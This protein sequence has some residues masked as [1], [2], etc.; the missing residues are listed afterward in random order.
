MP[1]RLLVVEDDQDLRG[2][3]EHAFESRG[4]S[5]VATDSVAQ[6]KRLLDSSSFDLVL[7]DVML[8][9]GTGYEVCR[10]LRE[11]PSGATVPVIMLTA[12]DALS[13]KEEGFAAGADNYLTKP[14]RIEELLLWVQALLRR[15][16]KDWPQGQWTGV[17][18]LQV[19]PETR[20]VRCAGNVVRGLTGKEFSLLLELARAAG[21]TLRREELL[22]RVWGSEPRTNTLEVHIGSLRRKLGP[23]GAARILTVKNVGYRLE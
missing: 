13:D 1:G 7:L 15:A 16:R 2:L 17:E 12:Q 14:I 21:K 9:D 19:D 8:P 23:Q 4:F 22:D 20:L 3:L 10:H 18:G 11:K 5:P 6:A